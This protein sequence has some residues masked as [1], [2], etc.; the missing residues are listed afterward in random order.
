M[1]QRTIPLPQVPTTTMTVNPTLHRRL[2]VLMDASSDVGSTL[3]TTS[4]SSVQLSNKVLLSE[5]RAAVQFI[6]VW[7][8]EMRSKLGFHVSKFDCQFSLSPVY[9]GFRQALTLDT[10][11]FLTDTSIMHIIFGQEQI[12]VHGRKLWDFFVFTFTWAHRQRWLCPPK[13]KSYPRRRLGLP[14][15]RSNRALKPKEKRKVREIFES[16]SIREREPFSKGTW[17]KYKREEMCR[18]S[19]ILCSADVRGPRL[20]FLRG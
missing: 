2:T 16:R 3:T 17:R 11:S 1:I 20:F 9:F 5:E 8:S 7:G 10:H 18:C 12:V 19:E 4:P 13:D 6:L 14:Q 15:Q